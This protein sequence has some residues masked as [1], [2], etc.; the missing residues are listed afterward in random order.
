MKLNRAALLAV[1][2]LLS[3]CAAN[4]NIYY[5]G[6]YSETAYNFKKDPTPA[7][8]TAHVKA[9]LDIIDHADK[10]HKKVPPGIYAELGLMEAQDHDKEKALQYFAMEK[11]LFP[12]SSPLIDRM[13]TEVK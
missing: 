3:A 6:D 10:Q 4:N 11:K 8:R 2:M 13:V 1:A 12:E 5:W 7:N 9:L